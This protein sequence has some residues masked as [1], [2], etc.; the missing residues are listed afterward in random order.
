MNDLLKLQQDFFAN[1]KPGADPENS[2]YKN[3]TA[4]KKLA[5]QR[6]DIYRQSIQLSLQNA[7][8]LTYP[9]TARL[10]TDKLFNQLSA[11]FLEK[12]LP[13]YSDLNYFGSQFPCFLQQQ[14]MDHLPAYAADLAKLE[15]AWHESIFHYNNPLITLDDW[16]QRIHEKGDQII[17]LPPKE[18]C[19]IVSA[20]P[21]ALIWQNDAQVL[22]E[23]QQDL[24]YFLI[25]QKAGV[26]CI[27]TLTIDAYLLLNRLSAEKTLL[28]VCAEITHE[29]DRENFP[30]LLNHLV[31]LNCLHIQTT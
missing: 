26:R 6:L 29:I 12:Q 2:F 16:Q 20:Y 1:C 7:L 23:K 10:L 22:L 25:W 8:I 21:L 17:L 14:S 13:T 30:M 18:S 24:F 9:A 4:P 3:F 27:E 28:D 31:Y 19:W 15:W 11:Q 5:E